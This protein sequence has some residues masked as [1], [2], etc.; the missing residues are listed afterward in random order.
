MILD[1]F[2]SNYYSAMWRDLADRC[3][4][5]RKSNNNSF[6]DRNHPL[7]RTKDSLPIEMLLIETRDHQVQSEFSK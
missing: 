2:R 3:N 5:S 4:T 1:T 6:S 7:S